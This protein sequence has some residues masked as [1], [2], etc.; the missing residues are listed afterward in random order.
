MFSLIYET[1]AGSTIDQVYVYNLF[2]SCLFKTKAFNRFNREHINVTITEIKGKNW[3]FTLKT[4]VEVKQQ[5][6]I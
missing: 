2:D 5:I 1:Q 4:F 3:D 6:K